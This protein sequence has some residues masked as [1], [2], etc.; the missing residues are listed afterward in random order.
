MRLRRRARDVNA[1]TTVKSEDARL[2]AAKSQPRA[3]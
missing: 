1:A 2:G 3:R